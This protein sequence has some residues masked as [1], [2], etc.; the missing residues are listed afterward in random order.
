VVARV[1]DD[2]AYATA[3]AQADLVA[4]AVAR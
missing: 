2:D 3:R 1:W 4:A